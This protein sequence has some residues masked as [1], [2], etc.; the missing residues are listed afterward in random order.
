MGKRPLFSFPRRQKID[1]LRY[2]RIRI[3]TGRVITRLNCTLIPQYNY[4]YVYFRQQFIIMHAACIH[5]CMH[6]H[7]LMQTNIHK[8]LLL[9]LKLNINKILVKAF[10]CLQV[11]LSKPIEDKVLVFISDSKPV[12]KGWWHSAKLLWEAEISHWTTCS[13]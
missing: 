3:I 11:Q 9:L 7:E 13:F 12:I 1:R 2:I 8:H 6:T 5:S 4:Q 10:I